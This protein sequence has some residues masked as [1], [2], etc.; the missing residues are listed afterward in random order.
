MTMLVKKVK[1]KKGWMIFIVYLT[2]ILH[3]PSTLYLRFQAYFQQFPELV[4][5]LALYLLRQCF[6]DPVN[7]K[8]VKRWCGNERFL[9]LWLCR[10]TENSN[11]RI[12]VLLSFQKRSNF[13]WHDFPAHMPF[14][15]RRFWY[16]NIDKAVRQEIQ[17]VYF[18]GEVIKLTIGISTRC[19]ES[20]PSW[21]N[22]PLVAV[23]IEERSPANL[24]Q[25]RE[26]KKW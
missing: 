3:N 25:N 13:L 20:L 7:K 1:N 23:L 24:Q 14:L 2:I 5:V 21:Y 6:L 26:W 19:G 18:G 17:M 10:L 12:C 15:V 11:D 8:D 22:D 4:T 16:L 9:F